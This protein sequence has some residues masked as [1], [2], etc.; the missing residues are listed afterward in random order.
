VQRV[1]TGQVAFG[2]ANAD[3]VVNARAAGAPLV[4]LFAPYQINPR[5]IVVHA[6]TGITSIDELAHVTL[7]LS[8]RPAFS[9]YLRH[10]FPLTGVDVVPY[11][12]SITPFLDNPRYAMQGYLFS[13]P[14]VARRMGADARALLVAD[15]GFNPYAST[16]IATEETLR[17]E[18][19]LV[20][21]VV[22]AARAGWAR[23]LESPAETNELI[24]RLNPEMDLE[25]LAA[26]AELSR[27]LVLDPVARDHGI[28]HMTRQ[29]WQTLIE[30][31]IEAGVVEPGAV[32]A[33]ACYTLRF[34]D[35]TV[36]GN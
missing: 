31:M 17:R 7:A 8:Q 14:V 25:I 19:E 30:Q 22:A 5:C 35:E 29:R 18:P 12:G 3:G 26:G 20:A 1:A 32:Q 15:T 4:A 2:L 6:S 9:H 13:E 27:D 11:H 10:R 28:G 33:Q 23:Y 16:L 36:S 24:H 34:L 21:A